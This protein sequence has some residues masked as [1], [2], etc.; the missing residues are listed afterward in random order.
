MGLT[1]FIGF[2]AE[3]YAYRS[4]AEL[5]AN[6]LAFM[7]ADLAA[8]D[9]GVTPWVVALVHKDWNMEAEAYAAF[10]PV[11]DAGNVD[12]LFCGHVSILRFLYNYHVGHSANG[13]IASPPPSPPPPTSL[14]SL[15]TPPRQLSISSLNRSTITTETFLM[16][17]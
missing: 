13:A 6:Q 14:S 12:V 4:G 8:V 9:R 7:K 1:H 17:Q 16:M 3:S 2:S 10:Y 15:L 5:L 11:L